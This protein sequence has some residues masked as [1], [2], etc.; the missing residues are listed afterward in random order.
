MNRFEY[1]ILKFSK[2]D[3]K[4]YMSTINDL[5]SVL[6]NYGHDGWELIDIKYKLFSTVIYLKKE[7][8]Y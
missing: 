5:T 1:K 7:L 8:K 4:L 2:R 6:N 3:Y